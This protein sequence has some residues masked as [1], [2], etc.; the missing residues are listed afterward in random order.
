ML[1][2]RDMINIGGKITVNLFLKLKVLYIKKKGKRFTNFDMFLRSK[3]LICKNERTVI[4]H[5]NINHV[6]VIWS[7]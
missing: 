2:L 4:F 5:N 3:T 7:I 1:V 6:L